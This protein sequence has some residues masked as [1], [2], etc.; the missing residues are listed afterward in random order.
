[1]KLIRL[2]IRL[3]RPHFLIGG[4]L[5]YALGAGIAHF[6]GVTINWTTYLLGQFW[7]TLLQLS[8]HFLNEY[9]DASGDVDNPNRTSLTGGSG[10]LG[11]GKLPR[12]TAFWSAVSCLV[13]VASLTVL[14]IREV[15]PNVS[16]VFF[17]VLI[18]L[19]AFFYAVPP[20]RL[21]STGYGE[22]TT[23][24]L[25]ANLVPGFAFLLQTRE[26]HR[27]LP[28]STF[29][30]TFLGLATLLAFEL[31]DYGTD[32]KHNKR[33]LMVR[34]GWQAGM[35]LHNFLILFSYLLLGLAVVLGL[36]SN[37]AWPAFLSL[38]V[39]LLQIWLMNRIAAGTK[40]NWFALTVTAGASFILMAYLLTY[41]FWIL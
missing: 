1:M 30:L 37:I 12:A 7:G 3:T 10:S 14:I 23:A 27:L 8:V 25:I 6:L 13:V 22:L 17:M 20:V 34:I 29:P 31:P 28:M 36:P 24:I 38:P 15:H 9:F 2:F 11:P 18:F 33:T 35:N 26:L 39:G 5:F 16:I 40:P 32:L 19:G 4:F 21:E 41:S